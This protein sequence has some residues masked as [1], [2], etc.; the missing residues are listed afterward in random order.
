[1][2]SNKANSLIFVNRA[3]IKAGEHN[4]W[5]SYRGHSAY[6]LM[7]E[8]EFDRRFRLYHKAERKFA[9]VEKSFRRA[10]DAKRLVTEALTRKLDAAHSE[11]DRLRNPLILANMRLVF[12]IAAIYGGRGVEFV[13]LVQEGVFALIRTLEKFEIDR[14]IKFSTYAAWWIRSMMSRNLFDA[15]SKRIIRVPIHHQEHENAI[16]REEAAFQALFGRRPDDNELLAFAKRRHSIVES[17]SLMK[18]RDLR[19]VSRIGLTTS[20][21]APAV[22]EETRTLKDVMPAETISP[23][24]LSFARKRLPEL[25][26]EVRKI[27]DVVENGSIDRN[28]HI[29]RMRF[30]LDGSGETHTLERVAEKYSLTRER[31]RQIVGSRLQRHKITERELRHKVESIQTIREALGLT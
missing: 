15:S 20:I 27:V 26:A 5:V 16:L 19:A 4:D 8:Q 23:E 2:P 28:S 12:K 6:E 9:A 21:D 29:I 7:D 3:S 25:E 11:R 22:G 1:M 18:I 13:D 10:V 24:M 17:F 30:G 31:I 14:G